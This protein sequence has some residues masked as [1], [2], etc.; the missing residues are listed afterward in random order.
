MSSSDSVPPGLDPEVIANLTPETAREII[1]EI[2]EDI[3]LA[4]QRSATEISKLR[5]D[6]K[7]MDDAT[8]YSTETTLK[9][10]TELI[11][12][13]RTNRPDE[14][15]IVVSN[16]DA[17][18]DT[19]AE[20]LD[21]EFRKNEAIRRSVGRLDNTLTGEPRWNLVQRLNDPSDD[22]G[23]VLLSPLTD[24]WWGLN[25]SGASSMILC[26]PVWSQTL[27]DRLVDA[28]RILGGTRPITIYDW[29]TGPVAEAAKAI[30]EKGKI[31]LQ[32]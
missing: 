14:K 20:A 2:E 10:I 22:L 11:I 27:W 28:I 31:V 25:L 12:K 29:C 9:V 3:A 26:G 32:V 16:S 21:R 4:N 24:A 15:M 13:I 30:R 6:L 7:A 17:F 8:L 18:L 19:I 5:D 1:R 23:V